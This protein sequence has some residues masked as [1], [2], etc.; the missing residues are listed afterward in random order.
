VSTT[1]ILLLVIA[2]ETSLVVGFVC[3]LWV[4][5]RISRSRREEEEMRRRRRLTEDRDAAHQRAAPRVQTLSSLT[6][7][8]SEDAGQTQRRAAV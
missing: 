1:S 2:I 6:A 3:G 7:T 8:H 5:S 4:M